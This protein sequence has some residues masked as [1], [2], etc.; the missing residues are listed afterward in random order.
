[1]LFN[2]SVKKIRTNQSIQL[3]HPCEAHSTAST[4]TLMKKDWWN[5]D[6]PAEGAENE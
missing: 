4:E 5:I 2:R 1:M 6:I 3:R